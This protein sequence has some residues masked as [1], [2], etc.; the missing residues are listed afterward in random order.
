MCSGLFF[1]D[2]RLAAVQCHS[3][4]SACFHPISAF[5]LNSGWTKIRKEEAT[6]HRNSVSSTIAQNQNEWAEAPSFLF[7]VG[8]PRTGVSRVVFGGIKRRIS[9]HGTAQRQN[10]NQERRGHCASELNFEHDSA[11]S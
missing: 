4:K 2:F 11:K 9:R 10:E 3:A 8:S 5:A 7:R 6:A 1:P